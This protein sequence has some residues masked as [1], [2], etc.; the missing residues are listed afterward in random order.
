MPATKEVYCLLTGEVS[1]FSDWR[2]RLY[3]TLLA[4]VESDVVIARRGLFP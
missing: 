3:E 1:A 4:T 2:L